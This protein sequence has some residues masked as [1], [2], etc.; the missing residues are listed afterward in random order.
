LDNKREYTNS[1]YRLFD[2]L[3]ALRSNLLDASAADAWGKVLGVAAGDNL[4]MHL[5]EVAKLPEDIRRGILNNPGIKNRDL[6]LRWFSPVS[7]VFDPRILGQRLSDT[8]SRLPAEVMQGIEFAAGQLENES[9]VSTDDLKEIG[10]CADSLFEYVT[11]NVT[12]P[13]L[14]MYLQELC[15]AIRHSSVAYRISGLSGLRVAL[16]RMSGTI[17]LLKKKMGD[18]EKKS[19]GFA[20]RVTKGFSVLHKIVTA[21][22]DTENLYETLEDLRGE[23]LPESSAVDIGSTT[24]A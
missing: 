24:V 12:E 10:D 21:K 13:E 6:Y 11:E 7:S 14:K 5:G 4:L 1:A 17:V 19:P 22:K 18:Q 2:L 16:E 8:L 15:E 9:V 20:A 3:N 23:L